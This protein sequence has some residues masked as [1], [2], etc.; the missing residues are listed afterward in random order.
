MNLVIDRRYEFCHNI[1]H[2]EGEGIRP[3][4][5]TPP[6]QT[7]PPTSRRKQ[8]LATVAQTPL[9]AKYAR[10]YDEACTIA[11]VHDVLYVLYEDG[12]IE[13]FEVEM[14]PFTV[15]LGDVATSETQAMWDRVAG[16]AAMIACRRQQEVA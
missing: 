3:E 15:V 5:A 8:V 6:P 7:S 10:V 1:E 13:P 16:G 9:K 2:K 14:A 11:K 12:R 4:K